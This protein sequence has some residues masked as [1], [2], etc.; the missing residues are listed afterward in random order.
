MLITNWLSA[1]VSRIRRRPRYN[2][3]ARRSI[4]KRL[5]TI[6]QNRITTVDPLEDRVMLTGFDPD[7]TLYSTRDNTVQIQVDGNYA[8]VCNPGSGDNALGAPNDPYVYV[9]NDNG[10]PTDKSDDTWDFQAE[11]ILPSRSE[12]EKVSSIDISGD[13]IV[14]GISV[15]SVHGSYRGSVYVFTRSG[16]TWSQQAELTPEAADYNDLD[17]FGDAVAISGDTIFVGAPGD[18]AYGPDAGS[19]YVYSRTG[20]SWSE[21]Q[22]LSTS[23]NDYEPDS[24]LDVYSK[25]FGGQ[26]ILDDG[27]LVVNNTING[28][29]SIFTQNG[30]IWEENQVLTPFEGTN[31]ERITID[32]DKLLFASEHEVT[33][34]T[35]TDGIWT[36]QAD[37]DLPENIDGEWLFSVQNIGISEDTISVVSKQGPEPSYP[38]YEDYE[39]IIR[40]FEFKESEW[41]LTQKQSLGYQ[42][43]SPS[44]NSGSHLAGVELL[45]FGYLDRSASSRFSI[46]D[47]EVVEGNSGE[48]NLIFTVT[49]S[50]TNAGDLN[51]DVSV[52]YEMLPGG[53]A[54]VGIDYAEFETTMLSFTADPTALSQTQQIAIPIYGDD[55]VEANETFSIRLL[56]VSDG[57]SITDETGTGTILNNDAGISVGDVV[58][59]EGNAGENKIVTFNVA[60]W[61]DL[62]QATSVDYTISAGTA[63]AGVDYNVISPAT[64]TVI[65]AADTEDAL[66]IETISIEIIGDNLVEVDKTLTVTIQNST[67][68]QITKSSATATIVNDDA[69]T[70][71]I[72][73]VVVSG[74]FCGE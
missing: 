16:E 13:T 47:A 69:A 46:S 62:N 61:G 74:R 6:Q 71:T 24:Y 28:T 12:W 39:Y 5:Q 1:L 49:R 50:G 18:D 17:L 36:H 41:I 64:G 30:G 31:V 53:T 7:D 35:S 34:Y 57:T 32:G 26:F 52:A 10:T 66:Q 43:P 11:L 22:K 19:V 48:K 15:D 2:S 4:R 58:V 27:T 45:T 38:G 51:S 33:I 3:R 56:P 44:V 60:R 63:V 54:L 70:L 65:F 25:N 42:Y 20:S 68:T 55:E 67:G 40:K 9:R 73:D 29:V 23:L 8:V 59:N 14:V 72:D 21:S 37:L